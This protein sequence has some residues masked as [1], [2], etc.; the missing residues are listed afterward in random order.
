MHGKGSLL[1]KMP[2]DRW[3]QFANLR[4]LYGY[5]W[6]H[7]GKKLLFMG[8]EFAPGARVEPRPHARLAPARAARRT[9]AC[10]A[11]VRDLNR[12][13]RDEPA[14]WE[15]DFDPAGFRWLEPNDADERTSSR[16]RACSRAETRPV[17]C[18]CNFSPV[19]R[20]GYRVGLPAPR[21]LARAAEHATRRSTAARTSATWAPS[22]A[23]D[24]PWHGQPFSA[25]VTLPPLATVWLVP[26]DEQPATLPAQRV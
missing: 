3:Q 1:D 16:S 6:A 17:V 20:H 10:S 13:Y 22:S 12:L 5:M 18:V 19:P 25:E 23:E 8:G 26:E 11:L 7:P 15:V 14:L 2:G 9:R 24:V 4:A 21:A